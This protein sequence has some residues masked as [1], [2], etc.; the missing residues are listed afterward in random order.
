MTGRA[1]AM[2]ICAAVGLIGLVSAAPAQATF[3]G[4]NGRIAFSQ[5]D[6]MPPIGGEPSDLSAHSQVFTIGP[7]GGGL[8]QLTHVGASD[9]GA[10]CA[11]LVARR[12]ADR[13]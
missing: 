11:R 9:Q 3:P 10:G 4:S 1:R 5:G 2:I 7:D 6:L 13:L 12:R 8:A